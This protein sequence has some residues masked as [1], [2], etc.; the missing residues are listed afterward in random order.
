MTRPPRRRPRGPPRGP[1]G[2]RPWDGR[3]EDGRWYVLKCANNPQDGRLGP[4][5]PLK[6]LPTKLVCA[7]LGHLL[8]PPVCPPFA[9]VDVPPDVAAAAVHPRTRKRPP[10][11][12]VPGPAFGCLRIE[13]AIEIKVDA[14]R[15]SGVDPAQV[16]RIAVFQTW[17]RGIDV[18]ALV[19]GG[20]RLHS[21]DHGYF[22]GGH[23]W[24]PERLGRPGPV[25][26]KLPSQWT[27]RE[28]LADPALF[29]PTLAELAAIPEED[30]TWTLDIAR[31]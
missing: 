28:R 12:A 17:L 22:L 25:R 2:T 31:P 7:R 27:S 26:L 29:A 1:G 13:D 10:Q 30:L 5:E 4:G 6:V 3:T 18:S 16:A 20:C 11:T 14:A 19:D 21:I 8:R 24:E 15:L 23:R 9:V